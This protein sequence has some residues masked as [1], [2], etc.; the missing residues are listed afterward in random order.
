MRWCLKTKFSS[1]EQLG[2]VILQKTLLTEEIVK[3]TSEDKNHNSSQFWDSEM[4][5]AG[6]SEREQKMMAA[7]PFFELPSFFPMLFFNFL[8]IHRVVLL[9]V[10]PNFPL[11]WNF[12][13]LIS[14]PSSLLFSSLPPLTSLMSFSFS[15]VLFPQSSLAFFSC[16][17]LEPFLI[18]KQRKIQCKFH[19]LLL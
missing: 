10:F 8:S 11:S 17:S 9:L 1:C 3:W 4:G 6:L 12:S 14:W 7:T 19:Y 2:I 18:L 16:Y 13:F 5:Q 15:L